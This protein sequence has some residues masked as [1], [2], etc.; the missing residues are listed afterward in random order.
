[1]YYYLKNSTI[2]IEQLAVY[3]IPNKTSFIHA[4]TT[5]MYVCMYACVQEYMY[6][7]MH[8]CPAENLQISQGRNFA[9]RARKAKKRAGKSSTAGVVATLTLLPSAGGPREP[10]GSGIPGPGQACVHVFMYVCMYV[11]M[12]VRMYVCMMYVCM[13]VYYMYVC[14]YACM[15]AGVY[16]CMYVCMYVYMCIEMH[17]QLYA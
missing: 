7:C 11:C 15:D 3:C 8:A 13:Y 16:V 9:H 4:L 12:Y 5:R 1:M 6:V 17:V 10:V 2:Q 14:M